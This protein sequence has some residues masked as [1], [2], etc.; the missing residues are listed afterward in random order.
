[1][2]KMGPADGPAQ[3][4]AEEAKPD[5]NAPSDVAK[6]P[7]ASSPLSSSSSAGRGS[8]RGNGA[9]P[10]TPVVRKTFPETWIWT[11]ALVQ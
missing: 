1:M 2:D 3:P 10:S 4:Q 7:A 6:A 9:V 5:E 11:D 8:G